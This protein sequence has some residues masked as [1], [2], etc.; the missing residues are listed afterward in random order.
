MNT[1]E[2]K[3]VLKKYLV[4]FNTLNKSGAFDKAEELIAM[5]DGAEGATSEASKELAKLQKSISELKTQEDSSL[6]EIKAAKDAA[7]K[8]LADAATEANGMMSFARAKVS[9]I[10]SDGE[11]LLSAA[12]AE[13]EAE[14][15]KLKDLQA[16]TAAAK[17]ESDAI[18]AA[19][20]SAKAKLKNMLS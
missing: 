1:S 16:K 9:D 3:A 14:N 18:N 8:I 19:L 12:K 20:E 10:Q 5:L 2:A 7:D 15:Q 6:A 13:V 11:K 17:E 4:A